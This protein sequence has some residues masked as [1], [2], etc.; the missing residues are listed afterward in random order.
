MRFLRGL[1]KGFLQKRGVIKNDENKC[2]YCG[3]CE[4]ICRHKAINV[5]KDE[6]VWIINNEKCFRCGHCIGKCP[7]NALML[8]LNLKQ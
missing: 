2:I 4:R 6:K 3:K 1:V 7:V 8:E 5:K